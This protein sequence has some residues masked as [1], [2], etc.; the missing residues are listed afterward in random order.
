MLAGL[1]LEWDVDL[2]FVAKQIVGMFHTT[3]LIIYS[4]GGHT[5]SEVMALQRYL[6]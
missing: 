1:Q 2:V 6:L 3:K 5:N 4:Q